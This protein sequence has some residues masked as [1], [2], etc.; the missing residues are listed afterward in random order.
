MITIYEDYMGGMGDIILGDIPDDT[1]LTRIDLPVGRY[2]ADRN[3]NSFAFMVPFSP[4]SHRLLR[5]IITQPVVKFVRHHSHD[6][7]KGTIAIV[8][9]GGNSR[10]LK[11]RTSSG[12]SVYVYSDMVRNHNINRLSPKKKEWAVMAML[13]NGLR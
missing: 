4:T 5:P 1:D 6:I 12:I 11:L 9:Y 2:I 13:G 8:V 3:G 10:Y 7:P